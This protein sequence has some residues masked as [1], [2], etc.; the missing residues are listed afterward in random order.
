MTY[1]IYDV[2]CVHDGKSYKKSD[3]VKGMTRC[4]KRIKKCKKWRFISVIL[5]ILTL[6][7]P[8]VFGILAGVVSSYFFLWC[9]GASVCLTVI[10]SMPIS[11]VVMHYPDKIKSLE[12]R[13]R[14]GQSILSDM[15]Y[16]MEQ[17]NW[18][19]ADFAERIRERMG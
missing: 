18:C 10:L 15:E 7:T 1:H 12:R 19:Y 9:W 8:A 2:T 6:V 11:M 17:D 3:I 14:K 4:K 5:L 16:I 13:M